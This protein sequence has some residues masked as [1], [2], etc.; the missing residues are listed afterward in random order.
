MY[1]AQMLALLRFFPLSFGD[2]IPVDNQYWHLLS[3]SEIIDIVMA[4][5]PSESMLCYFEIIY[6]SF[7]IQFKRLYPS[8]SL[9]PKMHF[10]VHLPT[11]LRKYG[12]MRTFGMNDKFWK[13]KRK[14][15]GIF[16]Y[17]N[18]LNPQFTLAYWRH[19]ATSTKV[20]VWKILCL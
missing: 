19:C 1:A 17:N 11:I 5:K 13:I 12:P 6:T 2:C 15:K 4:P 18:L 9:R 16:P 3:L 8:A 14:N 10:L 7:L 20:F